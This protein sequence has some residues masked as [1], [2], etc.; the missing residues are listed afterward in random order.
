MNIKDYEALGRAVAWVGDALAVARLA[1]WRGFNSELP[2]VQMM[3]WSDYV[4]VQDALQ[5]LWPRISTD[6]EI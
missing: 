4:A 3:Y 5:D 1:A 6:Y 2:L